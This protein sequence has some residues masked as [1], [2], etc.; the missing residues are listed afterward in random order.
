M[1]YFVVFLLMAVAAWITYEIG[2]A[3]LLDEDGKTKPPSKN[4]GDNSK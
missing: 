2:N 3:P 4:S 1:I